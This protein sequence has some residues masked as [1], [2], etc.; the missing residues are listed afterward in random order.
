MVGSTVEKVSVPVRASLENAGMLAIQLYAKTTMAL[1]GESSLKRRK[2]LKGGKKRCTFHGHGR[3]FI[4]ESVSV[5]EN[6][7]VHNESAHQSKRSR[8]KSRFEG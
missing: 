2:I 3:W 6:G 4:R 5:C 1:W 8:P 7:S